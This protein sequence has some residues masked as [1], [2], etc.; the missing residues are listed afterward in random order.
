MTLL[1]DQDLTHFQARREDAETRQAVTSLLEAPPSLFQYLETCS[2]L[3]LLKER[4][5]LFASFEKIVIFGTGGSSLGGKSLVEL[6]ASFRPQE[7]SPDLH[8]VD[9]VDPHTLQ[10]LF[11]SLPP[12]KTGFLVISKSGA[13]A[14]TMAQFL[15][16]L[17]FMKTHV[18][19]Q[20]LSAH[21]LVIT[22]PNEAPLRRLSQ[23]YHLKTLDHPTDVGGRFSVF[24]CVGLLPALLGGIRPEEVLAGALET[25]QT[26]QKQQEKSPSALG[27]SAAVAYEEQGARTMVLM[28]YCDRLATMS[29]WHRQ[30]W[31]ESLG[32][33]GKG[34]LPAPALGTVDQHSQLQLF[35]EGP[36]DKFFTLITVGHKGSSLGFDKED[37]AW[38]ARLGYLEGRTLE[39][40]M[41]AEQRATA[42]TLINHGCPVRLITVPA[43]TERSLGALMMHFVLE[44]ILAAELLRVN[45]FDQP[46]VEESK[47]LT[48]AYLKDQTSPQRGNKREPQ[49][50]FL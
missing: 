28:P 9:N 12:Q 13:T 29:A 15:A 19:P 18:K 47:R 34:T 26:F 31:A 48:R 7:G 49:G 16:A 35:L 11:E 6:N 38:D 33:E 50:L 23:H 37:L 14:E 44:T 24:T 3:S 39:D 45:A 40:L 25:W 46:A 5:R 30:L 4:A 2:D 8:F 43:L 17:A 27:A 21:F 32:K 20:E 36:K 42:Q 41:V 1:Y 10:S 22:E